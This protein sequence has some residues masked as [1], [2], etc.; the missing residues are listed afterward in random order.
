VREAIYDG[1]QVLRFKQNRIVRF[2]LEMG[3]HDMND[4]VKLASFDFFTREELKEFYQM[5]GYSLCGYCDVFGDEGDVV[6]ELEKR[7]G[8]PAETEGT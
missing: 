5:I 4:I 8:P 6:E 3:T 2:L 7:I 1:D